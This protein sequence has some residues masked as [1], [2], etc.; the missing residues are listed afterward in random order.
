LHP[1]S[2]LASTKEE[3][4]EEEEEIR[5]TT[6]THLSQL[7]LHIYSAAT[8]QAWGTETLEKREKRS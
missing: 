4:E 3:E 1:R 6:L 5:K 8:S 2:I 7:T